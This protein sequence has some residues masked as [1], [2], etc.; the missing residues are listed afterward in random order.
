MIIFSGSRIITSIVHDS[1]LKVDAYPCVEPGC[2]SR[3]INYNASA[4]QIAAL[5][6]LSKECHQFFRVGH[7]NYIIILINNHYNNC[8]ISMIASKPRL[9]SMVSLVRGGTTEMESHN[10]FGQGTTIVSILASAVSTAPVPKGRRKPKRR[11]ATVTMVTRIH[12]VTMVN[13][14]FILLIL[15]YLVQ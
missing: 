10:I 4:V 5:A 7:Q 12:I 3:P 6:D 14:C 11:D 9:N 1:E 15:Y 2:Y 13:H 8:L